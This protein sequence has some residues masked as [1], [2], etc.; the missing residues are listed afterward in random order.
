[1]RAAVL[2]AAAAAATLVAA[3]VTT[4]SP[5]APPRLL[6]ADP[7]GTLAV[8]PDDEAGG[9]DGR[10]YPDPD[11]GCI[12][13]W[14]EGDGTPVGSEDVWGPRIVPQDPSVQVQDPAPRPELFPDTHRGPW[15]ICDEPPSA[16]RD[17]GP[18]TG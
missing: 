3:G 18:G 16:V 12:R 5:S 4:S 6:A 15:P 14:R 1:M 2:L 10:L 11:T 13:P 17:G 9:F 8:P 7:A